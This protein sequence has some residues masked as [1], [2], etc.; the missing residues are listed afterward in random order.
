MKQL[1]KSVTPATQHNKQS[2]CV[3]RCNKIGKFIRVVVYSKLDRQLPHHWH[4]VRFK[5]RVSLL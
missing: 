5:L 3:R 4:F 2:K 1:D